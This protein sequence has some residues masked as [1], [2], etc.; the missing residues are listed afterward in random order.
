MQVFRIK[1][2][3]QRVSSAVAL[4]G[5]LQ[6]LQNQLAIVLVWRIGWTKDLCVSPWLYI[7]ESSRVSCPHTIETW[8]FFNYLRMNLTFFNIVL[9]N[10]QARDNKQYKL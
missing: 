3:Q 8:S 10:V 1:D 7:S 5:H 4:F 6:R 2:G 9:K